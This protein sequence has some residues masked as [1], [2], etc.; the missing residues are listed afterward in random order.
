MRYWTVLSFVIANLFTAGVLEAQTF[1]NP[2]ITGMN[3]DPSICRVGDDYYLVTSTFDYFPGLPVYHS[4]DL[5]HWKLIGHALSR[6]NNNP[7][8]G[9]ESGVGGQ[10]AATIRYHDGTFYVIGTNYGGKGS[11]GIS[12][13]SA[14]HPAGPWS[15]PVWLGRWE[16]DPSL[17]FVDGKCYYVSPDNKGSFL[18][19][20][21]DVKTG[22]FLVEPKKVADGLGGSSPEG[23]HLYKIGDYYYLMSA[24]GGTGYQHRE[25]IQRSKSP[26]GPYE[27]CPTNPIASNM[28]DPSNPFQAIGHADIVETPAGWWMVCL[29]IRPQGGNFQHLGRETFVAPVT[30]KDVWPRAGDDGIVKQEYPLPKLPPHPWEPDPARDN[31]DGETLGLVWNFLRNPHAD[32][33]SLSA[34]PGWLRLNGSAISF[35]EKDSP[36]LV[37]RRQTAFDMAASAKLSFTPTAPNEEAGLVVHANAKN[38]Y[39]L[40]VTQADGRRVVRFDKVLKDKLVPV[41]VKPLLDGDV[42]LRITA[43]GLE[44][45]F[46][47]QPHG[48]PAEQIGGAPTKDLANESTGGGFTGVFLGM[49]TS[50]NGLKNA[51]PSD[52]DW[53]DYEEGAQPPYGWNTPAAAIEMRR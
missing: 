14:K 7:L 17:L 48:Q 22:K 15:E 45:R 43:T 16:V 8:M 51:N 37:C 44:Y 33:W 39:K 27:P 12:Y 35:K 3:P 36:A 46:W 28:N 19:G 20:E 34:R 30:W 26:Y 21:L 32:D 29:G 4:K 13:V 40:V 42:V 31:F 50:G 10:Y 49:Y 47:I 11:Q 1:R 2:V 41:A 18:V 5:V 9:A 24:E 52:F 38:Y 25:V 53:F 23:P 6:P